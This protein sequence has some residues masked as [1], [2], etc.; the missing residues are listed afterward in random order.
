LKKGH[1]K[2]RSPVFASGWLCPVPQ[3]KD[4]KK[5]LRKEVSC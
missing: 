2:H 5:D 4:R 1:R 3:G